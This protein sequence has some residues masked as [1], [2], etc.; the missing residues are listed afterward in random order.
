[1]NDSNQHTQSSGNEVS[2]LERRWRLLKAGVK[3]MAG[4][5]LKPKTY[6]FAAAALGVSALMFGMPAGGLLGAGMLMRGATM[7][8]IGAM[9]NM[10]VDMIKEG[11]QCTDETH[12]CEKAKE[13]NAQQ[14]GHGQ[15]QQQSYYHPHDYGLDNNEI[16][17]PMDTPNMAKNP[18][19]EQ[20][21]H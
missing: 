11:K 5:L 20:G 15:A 18:H 8:A 3:G 21:R 2:F 1:M 9:M 6:V 13:A 4:Y 7:L 17:P 19:Q 10:A 14:H 16:V 12:A